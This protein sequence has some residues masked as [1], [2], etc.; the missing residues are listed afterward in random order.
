MAWAGLGLLLAALPL[1]AASLTACALVIA[2]LYCA[3]YGVT[4]AAGRAR[5]RAPGTS[6][7]VPQGMVL[8]AGDRR[9]VLTWG[10]I[11]GPG[12]LTRNP[13]AGFGLLPLILLASAGHAWAGLVTGALIGIMHGSG[14]G[15]ALLRDARVTAA[16][17]FE[18]LLTLVRWRILDG[19]A[20]LAI[21]GAAIVACG[22]RLG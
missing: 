10:A 15:L 14:R 2:V 21:A 17:P 8:G 12:F 6:W 1:P 3:V 7:Q 5:P 9:R 20:L 22:F 18:L 16:E 4:E 13:Y 11:L 19:L